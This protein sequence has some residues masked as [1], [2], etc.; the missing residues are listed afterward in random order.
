MG[1][2]KMFRAR[3]INRL[4]YPNNTASVALRR[5]PLITLSS[6]RIYWRPMELEAAVPAGNHI[7]HWLRLY[8]PADFEVIAP[9]QQLALVRL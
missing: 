2:N 6:L 8:D 3:E 9:R 4:A 1:T 7:L 5:R